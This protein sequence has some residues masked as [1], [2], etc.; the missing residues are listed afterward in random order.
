MNNPVCEEIEE[1]IDV[2]EEFDPEAEMREMFCNSDGE[3]DD[4]F[5]IGLWFD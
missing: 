3:P 4:G 2:E 1:D 5:D